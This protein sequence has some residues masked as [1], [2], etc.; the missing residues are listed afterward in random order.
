MKRGHLSLK[1]GM[2]G[3]RPPNQL[4]TSPETL[5]FIEETHIKTLHAEKIKGEKAEFCKKKKK[6]WLKKERMTGLYKEKLLQSLQSPGNK[7]K[8]IQNT[9]CV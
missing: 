8:D 2:K 9:L 5:K 1:G 4:I 7:L 6:L 3:G